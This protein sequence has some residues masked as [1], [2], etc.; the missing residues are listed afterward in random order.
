MI[1]DDVYFL[2]HSCERAISWLS[3]M[4]SGL[5][6]EISQGPSHTEDQI[7]EYAT[8]LRDTFWRNLNIVNTVLEDRF[9]QDIV[10]QLANEAVQ[11]LRSKHLAVSWGDRLLTIDKTR[12][13]GNDPAF[14]A[15]FQGIRESIEYDQYNGPDG[16]AWRLNTLC[17]AAKRALRVRADFVECGVF[18][19]DMA[20]VVLNTLGPERIPRYYLYDSF[21]G[22]SEQYSSAED[23][24]LNPGYLEFANKQYRQPALYE[25]VRD[26]FEIG[27][28]HV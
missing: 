15:A 2:K 9:K 10:V 25:R 28:A 23:F 8:L 13:F 12:G 20:W 16:I 22:F 18:E 3:H 14:A 21:E 4:L 6:K 27:R 11:K 1:D 7:R 24:P 19:G 5:A 26:R 17:W